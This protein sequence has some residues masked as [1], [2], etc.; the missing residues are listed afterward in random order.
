M[1]T[2]VWLE[3]ERGSRAKV[4]L[5]PGDHDSQQRLA[6][7]IEH[8][9]LRRIRGSLR[10]PQH[11]VALNTGKERSMR[12]AALF[13]EDFSL[14]GLKDEVAISGVLIAIEGQLCAFVGTPIADHLAL[15]NAAK[16]MVFPASQGKRFLLHLRSLEVRGLPALPSEDAPEV[17]T[18][19]SP[20]ARLDRVYFLAPGTSNSDNPLRIE[21]VTTGD[22]AM[23]LMTHS[24]GSREKSSEVFAAVTALSREVTGFAGLRGNPGATLKELGRQMRTK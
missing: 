21:P 22:L 11:I 23:R 19:L 14:E 15:A 13:F 5:E 20:T 24:V 4:I 1:T 3:T 17:L 12:R 8:L 2:S 7:M 9:S 6:D 10:R 18:P 16:E